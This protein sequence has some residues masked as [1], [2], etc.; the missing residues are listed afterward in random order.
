M[1]GAAT[2]REASSY[3]SFSSKTFS[4]PFTLLLLLS[5]APPS[6]FVFS[7]SFAC[8]SRLCTSNSPTPT[9]NEL[10][11][12]RPPRFGI[13]LGE[14]EDCVCWKS[15]IKSSAAHLKSTTQQVV[16]WLTTQ[17]TAV[18]HHFTFRLLFFLFSHSR[19]IKSCCR[20]SNQPPHQTDN[21]N[22]R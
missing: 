2:W 10:K 22:S 12:K 4:P 19:Q 15:D 21:M 9:K 20:H 16:V 11:K 13:G 14:D 8:R 7:F 6:N 17:L 1:R 18:S 5:W 3:S